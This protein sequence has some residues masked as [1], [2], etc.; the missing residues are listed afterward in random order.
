MPKLCPPPAHSG[1]FQGIPA[2][3]AVLSFSLRGK[4][5]C[6]LARVVV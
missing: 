4:H 5:F 1:A 2:Q 3:D 6:G